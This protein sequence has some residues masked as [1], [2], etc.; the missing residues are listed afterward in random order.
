MY[1]G[2]KNQ[3]TIYDHKINKGIYK[4]LN[5]YN[6]TS[7]IKY[8]LYID[9]NPL[10]DKIFLN[11]NFIIFSFEKNGSF[12]IKYS[13]NVENRLSEKEKDVV[14]FFLFTKLLE[15]QDYKK[16][17]VYSV[18]LLS[19][20]LENN[21]MPSKMFL[22][23][24]FLVLHS[25]AYLKYLFDFIVF[26]LTIFFINQNLK[27]LLKLVCLVTI[28]NLLFLKIQH[29]YFGFFPAISASMFCSIKLSLLY[30]VL[31]YCFRFFL[32]GGY[33]SIIK[34][35][36]MNYMAYSIRKKFDHEKKPSSHKE[37]VD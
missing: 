23:L 28:L 24:I 10:N 21:E 18:N 31:F 13:S 30:F 14:F 3:Y 9:G 33:Y 1:L 2:Y 34:N 12:A 35:G 22:T 16:S 17:I 27:G 19:F 8:Y 37:L 36:W 20:F 11:E 5:N 26:L 6:K 15:S 29:I 32:V 4:F 7:L 25:E